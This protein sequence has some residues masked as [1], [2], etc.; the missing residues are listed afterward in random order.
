MA[1]LRVEGLVSQCADEGRQRGG[2]TGRRIEGMKD[3]PV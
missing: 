3:L 2:C 1:D